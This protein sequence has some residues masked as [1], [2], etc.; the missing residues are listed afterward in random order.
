MSDNIDKFAKK[1][2]EFLNSVALEL[3]RPNDQNYALRVISA[4]FKAIRDRITTEES[5]HLI[6]QLPLYVKALYVDGWKPSKNIYSVNTL[7]KF[8]EEV[9][10]N[11]PRTADR[12][13]ATLEETKEAVEAVFTVIKQYA[14]P[15]EIDHI[16]AQL[17]EEIAELLEA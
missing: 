14:T 17:P 5:F 9:R 1:G 12:D 4:V 6:S 7:E 13:F 15:G 11:S 8:L 3:G 2:R 16:K 10:N